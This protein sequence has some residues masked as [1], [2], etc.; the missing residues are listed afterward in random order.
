M[1]KLNG[2]T[3]IDMKKW[4]IVHN[5]NIEALKLVFAAVSE[6]IVISCISQNELTEEIKKSGCL[7]YIG[8]KNMLDVP[9]GGYRIKAYKNEFG[10]DTVILDGD[11][12][13][14]ELY[15]AVDFK[16]KYMVKALNADVHMPIYY[17][18]DIFNCDMPEYDE[19]FVPYIKERSLWTWGYVIYDYKGYIDNMLRLKLNMLIIWNDYPPENAS[20][21][22]E[23]AH[24]KGV[25]I[26]WGFSWGWSTKCN[27]DNIA[28]LDKLTDD[29]INEYES[30]YAHLGGDGIYFQT[31][32]ETNEEKFGD[33]VIA[34]AAVKLV[35]Q[36]SDKLLKKYPNL[37]IQFGLHATSVKEK[38]E[39]IK[40]VDSRVTILWEDCGAFPYDYIP[41]RIKNFDETADFTGKIKN[42]RESGFGV[43]FKGMTALDWS[44]FEH[45]PGYF[46]I[47]EYDKAFTDKK[48]IEKKKIWKYVQA[49]WLS[50]AKYVKEIV[51][52]LDSDT[53]VSALVE[54]GLFDEKIWYPVAL[55]A[56]ILWNPKRKT[57]D[58]LT[59][60]ALIGDVSF[61]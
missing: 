61:A 37:H 58:I 47:G 5:G 36:T 10:N 3:D 19:S 20:E 14:N 16:N 22:I 25:K 23:Y 32:T 28:D 17:F 12:Y 48:L 13:V 55:Y 8:V 2:G 43:L 42:L 57:E 29:I 54:D 33:I 7:I 39:Y 15:S 49:Y 56:E 45:Q 35:N 38:L 4:F 30:R 21:L 60:T 40:N 1:P 52:M 41:K 24:K 27:L 6:Y 53:L 26:I 44:S 31:F 50:N 46:V 34:D 51:E 11:G 18:N 59:E 9:K